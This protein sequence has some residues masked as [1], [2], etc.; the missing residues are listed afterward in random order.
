MGFDVGVGYVYGVS[1]KENNR[2]DLKKGG[3]FGD[4]KVGVEG[5]AEEGVTGVVV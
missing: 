3:E 5:V 1:R 4:F 2:V